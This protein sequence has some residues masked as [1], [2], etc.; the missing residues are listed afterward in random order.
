MSKQTA[1]LLGLALACSILLIGASSVSA[2]K[3]AAVGDIECSGSDRILSMIKSNTPDAKRV[4]LLG[5][6]GYGSTSKCIKVSCDKYQEN[7]V[8][9]VG[10]HDK[11]SDIKKVFGKGDGVGWYKQNNVVFLG[12]NSEL[13]IKDVKPKVLN[14][15]NRFGNDSNISFIIPFQHKPFV[16][17][18]SAHHG[19]GDAKGYRAALLPI[20]NNN[21]KVALVMFGHN[22]GYQ[23]CTVGDTHFI[24]SGMGGRDPYPWGSKTD[25]GCTNQLSG[26]IGYLEVDVSDNELNW[27]LVHTK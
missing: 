21:E 22:H 9:T 12:I 23:Q 3:F 4:I 2:W 6:L 13:S 24:T 25:D 8:P 15:L 19:E 16:T 14:I 27:K 18:P 20:F 7:C 10:N 17:N 11:A 26:G 5:D 1:L